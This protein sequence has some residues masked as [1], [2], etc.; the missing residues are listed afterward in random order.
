MGQAAAAK[1]APEPPGELIV[2][3][4]NVVPRLL[5]DLF[6]T[7]LAHIGRREPINVLLEVHIT[8]AGIICQEFLYPGP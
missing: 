5:R 6:R 1:S 2:I 4:P 3:V 8:D 7:A